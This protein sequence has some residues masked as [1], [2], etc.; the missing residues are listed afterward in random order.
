MPVFHTPAVVAYTKVG[1]CGYTCVHATDQGVRKLYPASSIH[2][3]VCRLPSS[4]PTLPLHHTRR[5]DKAKTGTPL[6]VLAEKGAEGG[7]TI[8]HDSTLILE[9]LSEVAF[10][11]EMGHLYPTELK[12]QVRCV[13]VLG[14]WRCGLC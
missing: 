14:G 10:P 5:Q 13:V 2:R 7:P 1:C 6:L 8:L 9:H 12:D 4:N 3:G 11:Q